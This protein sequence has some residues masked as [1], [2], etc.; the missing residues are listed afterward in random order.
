MEILQEAKKNYQYAV[1]MRR[2]IHENPEVTGE[3]VETL[4]WICKEL[5]SMGIE[6]VKIPDGGI[7]G[8][9]H[10]GK[11]GKT[12]LLRADMDALPIQENCKNLSK[13][14]ICVSKNP[15]V[16]HACGHD[17]HT[18]MLLT[19]AKILNEHKEELNGNV[20]LCFEQGEEGGGQVRNL[21]PYI[22]E[23]AK[24]PVDTCF[25]THVKWD[26]PAGQVSAEPGAVLSGGYGFEIRLHGLTGHGSRPDLAHSVLDCFH[27]I[28]S[29]MN[30]LRIKYVSPYDI[31]TFSVGVVNC[32]S[33]MNIIP[34][35]LT[36]AGTVRTF[37]VEGAGEAFMKEFMEI[38]EHETK[39]HHCTYEI[40]HLPK[41]LFENY[42]NPVCSEIAKNAVRK[43]L[44]EEALTMTVPWMACESMNMY[45]K[46]WP[47]V[48]SFTGIQ[49]DEIGSG[50]NHHTAE[51]DVDE[52]GM[53]TGVAAALAYVVEF[54][55]Y[56]GEVPF[57]P[58]DR[59]LKDLVERNL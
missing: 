9:I 48:I 14:K 12:V 57:K 33:K 13:E 16:S 46:L 53:I 25:A 1:S 28:Y 47:G 21:L 19:E 29:N 41:P 44:G 39:V 6:Y 10:G 55:N 20:V 17:A 54:L 38:I 18:A 2:H 27:A 37:N 22:I 49:S 56:Q 8:Q 36:F 11:P 40:L 59:P 34:D 32:G 45:L 31:L 23:T 50:A 58:Y 26:V 15:G 30:M 51:F 35:E 3:E 4:K 43:H 7:I 42:N 5:D 52:S 24:I